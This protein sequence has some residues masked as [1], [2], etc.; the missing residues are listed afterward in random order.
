METDDYRQCDTEH[1][2]DYP[3]CYEECDHDKCV[4]HLDSRKEAREND[5]E[6]GTSS[7]GSDDRR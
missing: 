2:R 3:A 7:P 6:R 5:R 4:A 1:L